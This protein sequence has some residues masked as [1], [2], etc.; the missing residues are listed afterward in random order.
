[1]TRRWTPPRSSDPP[2]KPLT[3]EVTGQ[4]WTWTYSYP[5][6]G[7]QSTVLELPVGQPVQFRVT[8]DDVLHGFDVDGLG[9]LIDA[10]P[11]WWTTAPT[12]TPTRLG[13]YAVRCDE[14][15]GL[16]HTYMWSPVK[17]VSHLTSPPGSRPTEVTGHERDRDPR[18]RDGRTH[19]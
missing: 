4:Q 8:S 15:C 6:L 2:A 3:I 19:R 17:V 12:V 10:N 1:M 14:L 16:Y 13:S 7:V 18:R 5:S 9:V 11:G